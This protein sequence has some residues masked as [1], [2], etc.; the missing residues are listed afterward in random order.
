MAIPPSVVLPGGPP[1]K[2]QATRAAGLGR[3]LWA[4]AEPTE[5]GGAGGVLLQ[6]KALAACTEAARKT[7][8]PSSA[9]SSRLACSPLAPPARRYGRPPGR[10]TPPLYSSR[11]GRGFWRREAR[12][13]SP[14]RGLRA[15]AKQNT[16][17][18]DVIGRCPFVASC[19]SLCA[20]PPPPSRRRRPSRIA[21]RGRPGR[22]VV[23]PTPTNPS[24]KSSAAQAER[25]RMGESSTA[26]ETAR[27]PRT[28]PWTP[29]R[30]A[31]FLQCLAGAG[32]SFSWPSRKIT[33]EQGAPFCE[34]TAS[35]TRNDARNASLARAANREVPPPRET[36][37]DIPPRR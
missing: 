27:A 13:S 22:H 10:D 3:N 7:S 37:K 4:L 16:S 26:D 17:A 33:H 28:P 8:G 6:S 21:F 12:R 35:G 24:A 11:A 14:K 32:G 34:A 9:P 31:A 30:L 19:S 15:S 25:E 18:A 5:A 2:H 36:K 23:R 1:A 29:D 20:P